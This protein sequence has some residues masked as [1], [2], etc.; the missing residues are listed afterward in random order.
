MSRV[1]N[2]RV[3]W[4]LSAI[5]EYLTPKDPGGGPRAPRKTPSLDSSSSLEQDYSEGC[6]YMAFSRI[7]RLNIKEK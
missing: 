5:K 1:M 2:R 6:A 3:C 7:V 4:P